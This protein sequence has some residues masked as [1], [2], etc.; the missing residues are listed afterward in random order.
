M[1]DNL[2]DKAEWYLGIAEDVLKEF[3]TDPMKKLL[4]KAKETKDQ[5]YLAAILATN[6]IIAEPL[7]EIAKGKKK[8][9]E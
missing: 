1:N 2:M 6:I 5:R 3:P 7:L 8:A 9:K 4:A